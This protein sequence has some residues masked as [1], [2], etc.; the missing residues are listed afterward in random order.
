[1]ITHLAQ[2][3]ARYDLIGRGI[4]QGF[5]FTCQLP[6]PISSILI[7]Q[8]ALQ[9]I[10]LVL[11]LVDI[12]YGLRRLGLGYHLTLLDICGGFLGLLQLQLLLLLLLLLL[13]L[14]L[15][16]NLQ[17][18]TSLGLSLNPLLL[19]FPVLTLLQL[20]AHIHGNGHIE[21]VVNYKVQDG[22]P[23]VVYFGHLH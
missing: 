9:H 7:R 18:L 2:I 13:C 3:L 23:D 21:L 17:L 16:L 8:F 6:I 19:T 4:N 11:L 14:D 1:M 5:S 12:L 15:L 22:I 10:L 20:V